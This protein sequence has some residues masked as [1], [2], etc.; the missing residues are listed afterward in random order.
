MLILF[1]GEVIRLV[2]ANLPFKNAG[3]DTHLHFHCFK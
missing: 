2:G 1:D 3:G